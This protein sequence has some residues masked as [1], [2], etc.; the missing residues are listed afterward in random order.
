MLTQH[1]QLY[2]ILERSKKPL[3]VFK[4]DFN[5]DT[6]A[7]ALAFA[8]LLDKLGKKAAIACDGFVLPPNY[9]FLM[10]EQ[11]IQQR[12]TNIKKFVLI[13]NTANITT[14]TVEHKHADD[15]LHIFINSVSGEL[16]AK[17][18]QIC[19]D[20][21]EYD[22]IISLNSPDVESLGKIYE[23][24][25]NFFYQ[26]PIINI[27]HSPENEHFGQLNFINITATSVSEIIFEL[28]E[29]IDNRLFD[30]KISTCLLAGMID[31]TKSFKTT[32]VTPKCLNIASQLM[33]NGAEREF[34]VKNLY[35]TKTVATLRL[36]GRILLNLQTMPGQ[37]IAW[38]EIQ[39]KDFIETGANETDL[40]A[41]ID[42]LIVTIPN[43]ELTAINY[44]KNNERFCL[45]KSEKNH[46]LRSLFQTFSP[47]GN[48]SCVRLKITQNDLPEILTRLQQLN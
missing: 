21:Y 5:G 42:E 27:D 37:K 2:E 47:S 15:K 10:G 32:S 36:W 7:S 19:D 12:L 13:I 43:I 14:P 9:A 16:T 20:H 29:K 33:A 35:Q 44:E 25:T 28:I 31:K 26:T 30:E 45:V 39:E 17:D 11:T 34:I 6:L 48:R 18:L 24:N 46:D 38:A 3:L 4:K 1:Q 40:S 23:E 41:L 8:A 22:L